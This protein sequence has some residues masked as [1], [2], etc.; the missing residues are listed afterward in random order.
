M[1][2]GGAGTHF[3]FTCAVQIGDDLYGRRI[4]HLCK[5]HADWITVEGQVSGER[6][7]RILAGCRFGIQ[8]REA[9]PFGISVAEMV[10]AGAIVFAPNDGGQAEILGV[11]DLLFADEA[12]G[13][14]KVQ[15][16]LERPKLQTSMRT[17]LANRAEA[18]SAQRFMREARTCIADSL[19]AACEADRASTTR[20]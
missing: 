10:K 15:A 12:E 13:V 7:A 6:K 11:P 1:P 5:E 9:E 4:A 14:E 19:V 16:V 20:R 8:T 2:S 3:N 17:H 18:F